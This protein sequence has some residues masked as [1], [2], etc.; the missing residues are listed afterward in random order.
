MH[1]FVTCMKTITT[2]SA[3]FLWRTSG[4]AV[5]R[6]GSELS[7]AIMKAWICS[8]IEMLPH[9]YYLTHS[10]LWFICN[11]IQKIYHRMTW[12]SWLH[13]ERLGIL[14]NIYINNISKL[15]SVQND[16]IVPQ[17]GDIRVVQRFYYQM[18]P[19][20]FIIGMTPG[21]FTIVIAKFGVQLPSRK[22]P[23]D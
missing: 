19:G 11:M 20:C 9:G 15:H 2:F 23:W 14:N 8:L 13:L 7:D 12:H 17:S 1:Y 4:A 10:D 3:Y 5:S 18:L 16:L 6:D 21:R 22:L